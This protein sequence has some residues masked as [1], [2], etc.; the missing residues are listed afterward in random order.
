LL[1][2]VTGSNR[3]IQYNERSRATSVRNR[4]DSLVRAEKEIGFKA[5]IV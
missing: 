1:L 3:P 5:E 2:N 4:I